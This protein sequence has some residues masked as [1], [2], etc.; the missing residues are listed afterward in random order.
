MRPTIESK[1]GVLGL[2]TNVIAGL[3][4]SLAVAGTSETRLYQ[5]ETE[6]SMP[7]LEQNLRYSITHG[8]ECLTE[9]ELEMRFPVLAH[10]AISDCH[11]RNRRHDRTQVSYD[12]IC[13]AG[14]GTTGTATW[15]I[16]DHQKTGVLRVKLGGKNMT[17]FERVTAITLGRCNSGYRTG[18]PLILE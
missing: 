2:V 1:A 11:L 10:P 9:A 16:G 17:F 6:L 14:H 4:G 15:E 18:D 8:K 13:E 7:N 5:I 12:L 3:C